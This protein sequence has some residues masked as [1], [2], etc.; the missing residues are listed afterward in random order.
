MEF[1]WNQICLLASVPQNMIYYFST[2][3]R[4]SYMFGKA[5]LWGWHFW[6]AYSFNTFTFTSWAYF[7]RFISYCLTVENILFTPQKFLIIVM[8]ILRRGNQ[9]AVIDW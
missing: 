7:K 9:T 6:V 8:E 3:V 2:K 5:W 1:N 4:K